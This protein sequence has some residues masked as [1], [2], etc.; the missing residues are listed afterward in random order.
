MDQV[1][2]PV[3]HAAPGLGRGPGNS[4]YII[5]RG[6]RTGAGR[7]SRAECERRTSRD[8]GS[9]KELCLAGRLLLSLF[10]LPWSQSKTRG[11]PLSHRDSRTTQILSEHFQLAVLLSMEEQTRDKVPCR[12]DTEAVEA[13]SC[14]PRRLWWQVVYGYPQA[15]CKKYGIQF[16][17]RGGC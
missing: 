6:A 14:R 10:W 9:W 4:W 7:L 8:C 2:L 12:H 13:G 5:A 1:P 11:A 15:D 16:G 17:V 3:P